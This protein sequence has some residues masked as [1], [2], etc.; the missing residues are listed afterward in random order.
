MRK[1]I[2]RTKLKELEESLEKIKE[3]LP[4]K[5]EDFS[6]MGIAKDGIYKNVEFCIQQVIDICS[7]VNSDL[8]LGIPQ[9]ETDIIENLMKSGRLE[10]SLGR[11]IKEMKGFRNI[12]VH[13]YSRINDEQ[14]FVN[15]KNGMK[16][17]RLFMEEIEDILSEES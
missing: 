13:R 4:D 14:A 3:N 7:V 11:K 17:L 15:I 1:K 6:E 5:F 10:E 12:L 9:D 8:E 2:I 16:D